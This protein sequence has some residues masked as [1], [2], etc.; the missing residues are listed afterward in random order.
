MPCCAYGQKTQPWVRNG[1]YRASRL[2]IGRISAEPEE[3]VI[4][5]ER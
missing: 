4:G 5:Q 2:L 3:A 1:K